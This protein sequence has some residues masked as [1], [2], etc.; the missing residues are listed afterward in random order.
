MKE[1]EMGGVYS[2]HEAGEKFVQNVCWK[3]FSEEITRKIWA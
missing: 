1:D 2:T 3:V